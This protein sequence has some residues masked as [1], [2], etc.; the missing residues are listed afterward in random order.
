[1]TIGDESLNW[2][3]EPDVVCWDGLS[4]LKATSLLF[5]ISKTLTSLIIESG[6]PYCS[7]TEMYANYAYL[8]WQILIWTSKH[9][10]S[11]NFQYIYCL[12]WCTL[13]SEW[14]FL[15]VSVDIFFYPISFHENRHSK[16]LQRCCHGKT[17]Q[18]CKFHC[19]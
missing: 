6:S 18:V 19:L 15:M 12:S 4:Y 9:E 14:C 1:M 7:Y 17:V 8:I 13:Q 3:F 10:I 11:D 2:S 16:G 5:L